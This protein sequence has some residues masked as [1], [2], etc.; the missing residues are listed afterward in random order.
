MTA[1]SRAVF[2][3]W[4]ATI[5][6]GVPTLFIHYFARYLDAHTQ[7]FWRYGSALMFLYGYGWWSGEWLIHRNQ[8]AWV[9]VTVAA[10]LLVAY[11]VCFTLSLY[12]AMPAIVSLLIQTELIV[13]I[14]LSCLFFADE[15]HVARSP[16]FI[17]GACGALAG[18]VGMVVFSPDFVAA[19][20]HRAAWDNLAI[21][22]A[23]VISAAILW[24][25]YSVAIKW[26]LEVAPPFQAFTGIATVATVAF[27]VL[28]ATHGNAGAIAQTPSVVILAVF[29]SGVG[30]IAIAQISYGRAIQQLGVAVCNAVILT[31]PIVAAI[32]SRIIFE[33]RFTRRQII[34]AAVLLAGAAAAIQARNGNRRRGVSP[35]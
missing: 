29:L 22:V 20:I 18:A 24:G 2:D 30:C 5:L 25:A 31:S 17:L 7:N 26:C 10:V 8:R 23:L 21:A 16:W 15:R 13:A 14:V 27:L 19:E 4:L 11:Q 35:P 3:I 28:A 12:R 1:R 32:A 6:W 9:R 33:E 34:S